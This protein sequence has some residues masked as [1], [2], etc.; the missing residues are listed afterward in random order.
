MQFQNPIPVLAN[1]R[2]GIAIYVKNGSSIHEDI[3]CVSFQDG[4]IGYFKSSQIKIQMHNNHQEKD[5]DY[6]LGYL[7]NKNI[8][9][10][11]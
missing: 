2:N 4:S 9:Q 11:I 3:W 1:E 10:P 8:R 6:G 5:M 7:M